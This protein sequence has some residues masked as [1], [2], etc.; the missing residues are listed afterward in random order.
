MTTERRYAPTSGTALCRRRFSSALTALSLARHLWRIVCLST[1]NLP[2]RVFAQL[3]VKPRK[4][5]VSGFPSPRP[6]RGVLGEV[7]RALRMAHELRILNEY[8]AGNY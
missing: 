4:L 1:V 2:C 7:L 5:K 8:E 3:C 6:M